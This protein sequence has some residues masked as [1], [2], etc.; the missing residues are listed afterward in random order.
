M[1]SS[2]LIYFCITVYHLGR[3]CL[4]IFLNIKKKPQKYIFLST[5]KTLST[6]KSEIVIKSASAPHSQVRFTMGQ[7][8]C[9]CINEK[10]YDVTYLKK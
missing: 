5:V 7:E 2:P 4:W 9:Q 10:K 8:R 3:D 1:Q 6:P